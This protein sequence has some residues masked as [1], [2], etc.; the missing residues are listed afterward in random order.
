MTHSAAA[1]RTLREVVSS[2]SASPSFEGRPS[3]PS[4]A[5]KKPRH[6]VKLDECF[7]GIEILNREAWRRHFLIQ[8][9]PT[10]HSFTARHPTTRIARM[11]WWSCGRS[12]SCLSG[13]VAFF[14]MET[15]RVYRVRHRGTLI[16]PYKI[17]AVQLIFMFLLGVVRSISYCPPAN[18]V[19]RLFFPCPS[20]FELS[21][22]PELYRSQGVG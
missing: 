16:Y 15:L 17:H 2:F 6:R 1:Q 7:A 10:Y 21:Y 9:F 11:S 3:K 5:G 22:L 20:Q 14:L 18:F 8:R 13:D 4:L 12:Q 19:T